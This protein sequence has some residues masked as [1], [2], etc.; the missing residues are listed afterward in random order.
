MIFLQIDEFVQLFADVTMAGVPYIIVW[1]IGIYVVNTLV[2]WI[3]GGR[4][5]L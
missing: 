2:E 3:T 5:E 1:R 4:N